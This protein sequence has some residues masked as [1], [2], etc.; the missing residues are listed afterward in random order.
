MVDF[1]FIILNYKT[2]EMTYDCISC[3]LKLN[4]SFNVVVVDNCGKSDKFDELKNKIPSNKIYFC[5]SGKNN[6]YSAGN[7]LDSI[8]H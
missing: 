8:T 4:G 2:Y 1:T 6:G 3:L 5:N 7:N